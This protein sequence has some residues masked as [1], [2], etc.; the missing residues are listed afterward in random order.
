MRSYA[1]NGC[2]RKVRAEGAIDDVGE[3]TIEAT[4]SFTERLALGLFAR[5]ASLGTRVDAQLDEGV[6]IQGA[7]DLP[8][9]TGPGSMSGVGPREGDDMARRRHTPEQLIS[10]LRDE[11]LDREILYATWEARVL[12]EDWRP[13]YNRIRPHSSLGYRP[14]APEAIVPASTW[15]SNATRR[16]TGEEVVIEAR[17]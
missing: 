11:L 12:I 1:S 4:E 15:S 17:T 8:P 7:I 6:R 5:H 10:K 2:G 3:V 13:T 14:P 16:R 9:K